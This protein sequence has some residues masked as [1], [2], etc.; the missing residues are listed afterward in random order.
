MAKQQLAGTHRGKV[1]GNA[2][3]M[4]CGRIKVS[5]A[6]A[7]GKQGADVLPW[8]WPK[9]QRSGDFFVP[10]IGESVYVEFLC[11][12]GEPDPNTPIWTGTWNSAA[13]VPLE[14]ASDSVENAHY[15]PIE[16]TT[17]G[18]RILICDK[19]NAECIK[20]QHKAGG[21]ILFDKDGNVKINGKIIYLN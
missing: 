1:V 2:D 9:Y 13:E 20:I 14:V 11:T 10:E 12:D 16:R 6:A 18:H 19:P 7:Y 15:Y 17:A 4:R 8:A 5:V 21:T 3:P